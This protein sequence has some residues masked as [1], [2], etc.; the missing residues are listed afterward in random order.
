MVN[1]VYI[2]AKRLLDCISI[3][4]L[5]RV[6]SKSLELKKLSRQKPDLNFRVGKI[7]AEDVDREAF[8][9]ALQGVLGTE[10]R[11]DD[12]YDG[13]DESSSRL[14][15]LAFDVRQDR[16][17]ASGHPNTYS[18]SVRGR[19]GWRAARPALAAPLEVDERVNEG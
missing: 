16:M 2:W 8:A 17:L 5:H 19:S 14:R 18:I 11:L 12:S 1:R 7:T 6:L 15:M 3:L 4:W 9:K 13:T 10:H